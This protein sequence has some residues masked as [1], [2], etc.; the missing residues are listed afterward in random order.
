MNTDFSK[1]LLSLISLAVIFTLQLHST[2]LQVAA[3]P[4]YGDDLRDAGFL[5]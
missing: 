5:K 2:T 1:R 3:H 4:K